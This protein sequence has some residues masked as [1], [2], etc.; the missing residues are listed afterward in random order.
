MFERIEPREQLSHVGV[1][2]R[3][4]DVR[5]IVRRTKRLH[6]AARALGGSGVR[7]RL[8]LCGVLRDA[9]HR[10]R[11][12]DGHARGRPLDTTFTLERSTSGCS[13]SYRSRRM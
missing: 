12:I 11:L 9:G 6:G 2:T 8:W 13:I 5:G 4:R 10:Q 7:I 1:V 3:L